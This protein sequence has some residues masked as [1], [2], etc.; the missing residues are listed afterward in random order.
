MRA[1]VIQREMDPPLHLSKS[2]EQLNQQPAGNT[3][4]GTVGLHLT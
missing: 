1:V 2:G 3:G 4:N